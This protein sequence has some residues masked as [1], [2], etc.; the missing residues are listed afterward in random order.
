[1]G[2]PYVIL[3]GLLVLIAVVAE[4]V[5]VILLIEVLLIKVILIH[6]LESEGLSSKPVDGT[7]NQLLLDVLTQLVVKLE[8]LLDVGSGVIIVLGWCL[9]GREE[10]EERLGGDSLLDNAGLFCV[11]VGSA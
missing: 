6:L 1:M 5:L 8:A 2:W 4:V 9:G 10:V 7:G 3:V 11:W